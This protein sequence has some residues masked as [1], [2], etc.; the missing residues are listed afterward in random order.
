VTEGDG[1]TLVFALIYIFR[2]VVGVEEDIIELL[3]VAHKAFTAA[4]NPMIVVKSL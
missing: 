1:P 3:T 4:N 2:S